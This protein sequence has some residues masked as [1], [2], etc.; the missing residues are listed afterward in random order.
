MANSSFNSLK[1]DV[2]SSSELAEDFFDSLKDDYAGFS[3]WYTKKMV[4]GEKA[5]T[6]RGPKKRLDGFLYL[7]SECISEGIDPILPPGKRLKIG[8]MKINAHGTRLGERFIK[9]AFDHA[10]NEK[11]EF[12]YVT[13]FSKHKS[14]VD[15][16]LRYGFKFHGYKDTPDGREE[17]F[18]KLLTPLEGN[19]VKD[20]PKLGLKN[21]RY[22]LLAI[23]PEY[24]SSFLPES[25]LNNES[26]DIL[27]DVSHTNSIHKIY[28]SG[29]ARAKQMRS[30]DIIVIY[31]T[32]DRPGFAKFRSVATS[33]VVVEEVRQIKSFDTES[34]FVRYTKPYSVFTK[35]ELKDYFTNKKKHYIIKF[36]YNAA[37]ATRIIRGK[38]IDE[39]GI[40][41]PRWDLI[42]LTEDQVRWIADFGGVNE[43]LIID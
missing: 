24:H 21:K 23:Y 1:Y 36:T 27:E 8:T 34:E 33:I 12:I 37:L 5:Y 41:A 39:C 42:G 40:A 18:L 31:R 30:G 38:L 6:F 7:K 22:F 25:I 19:P 2:F 16:F 13:V 3:K 10:I 26:L 9:K 29:I 11:V 14:L 17:V 35:D 20:F 4:A 32:T 43:G 28:I 15:L